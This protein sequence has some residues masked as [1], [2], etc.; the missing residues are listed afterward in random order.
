LSKQ[1]DAELSEDYL[2]AVAVRGRRGIGA[3]NLKFSVKL[4][5]GQPVNVPVRLEFEPPENSAFS[6]DDGTAYVDG[7]RGSIGWINVTKT[8]EDVGLFARVG[9]LSGDRRFNF[10]MTIVGDPSPDYPLPTGCQEGPLACAGEASALRTQDDYGVTFLDLTPG[11]SSRLATFRAGWSEP[12]SLTWWI[13]FGDD[14]GKEPCTV[15]EGDRVSVLATA[16][17][18]N[19][20]THW[21]VTSAAGDEFTPNATLCLY[22]PKGGG[23]GMKWVADLY[24][25]LEMK[26][27]RLDAPLDGPDCSATP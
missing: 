22:P 18:A 10:Q 5:P 11:N 8:G 23:R 7:D 14:G 6:S 27:C 9:P 20:P 2:V 26:V 17:D 4:P 24:G 15:G 25:P 12:G 16:F 13:F 1:D 3:E 21:T 19:S